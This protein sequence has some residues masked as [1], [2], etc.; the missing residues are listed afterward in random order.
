LG[1]VKTV[2]IQA[3][4]GRRTENKPF[5]TAFVRPDHLR[6]EYKARRGDE[7]EDRYIIWSNGK[8]VQTWWDV[9]PGIEKPRTLG[10]ALG[11]AAGVSG[12]SS[13]T[14][15]ALL[16]AEEVGGGRLTDMTDAKRI[17]DAKLD[18]V[19]CFRVQGKHAES[20]MTVWIDKKTLLIRRIETQ[21]KFD[22][23]RT[24]ETTTYDLV[25]DGAI[26][27]KMLDCNPPKQK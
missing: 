15:P 5:T 26:T 2:F 23:F 20:L 7:E 4:D 16:L 19:D 24:E 1:I 8:Y 21:N 22:T 12:G 6:F 25:M 11:S 3:D 14:I 10:L 18:G 13:L 9:R 27:D 17:K